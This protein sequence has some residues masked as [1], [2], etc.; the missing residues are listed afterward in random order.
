MALDV[1]SAAGQADALYEALVSYFENQAKTAGDSESPVKPKDLID[2]I[3]LESL[4]STAFSSMNKGASFSVGAVIE[5]AH[6]GMAVLREIGMVTRR[7]T[8]CYDDGATDH[9]DEA[10]YYDHLRSVQVSAIKGVLIPGEV[11]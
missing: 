11:M 9:S 3:A 1:N 5:A 10:D 2:K 7:K 6:H 8:E 4:H